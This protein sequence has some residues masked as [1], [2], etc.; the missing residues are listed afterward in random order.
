MAPHPALAPSSALFYISVLYFDPDFIL[1]SDL[2]T[3]LTMT[4]IGFSP[5]RSPSQRGGGCLEIQWLGWKRSVESVV[6]FPYPLC[7]IGNQE[8]ELV[9]MSMKSIRSVC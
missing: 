4:L 2:P 7:D 3:C 6:S 9:E 1:V 5:P 8:G